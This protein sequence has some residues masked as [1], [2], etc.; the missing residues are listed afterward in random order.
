MFSLSL[1][2]SLS[3][4]DPSDYDH[5]QVSKEIKELFGYI[6][7][8]T[9]HNIELECRLMPFVPEYVPAIGDIDAFIKVCSNISY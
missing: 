7:R 3:G 1:S 2:L 8:Y 5:L 9:P 4:Y 6:T